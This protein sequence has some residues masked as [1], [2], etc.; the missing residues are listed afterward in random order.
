MF[1]WISQKIRLDI[2]MQW[3]VTQLSV[4]GLY[5]LGSWLIELAELTPFYI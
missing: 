3:I 2:T 4:V 5:Y 1:T